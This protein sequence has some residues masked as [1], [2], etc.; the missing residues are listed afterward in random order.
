MPVVVIT[1]EEDQAMLLEFARLGISSYLVKPPKGKRVLEVAKQ[2][3]DA[4]EGWRA[5]QGAGT[6]EAGL[7]LEMVRDLYGTVTQ[8]I[9]QEVAQ[10]ACPLRAVFESPVYVRFIEF[11]QRHCP[12][13]L[14]D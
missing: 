12:R 5:R 13:A 11:L 3:L 1:T 7:S 14:E 8:S 10:P 4:S 9:E 2:A 6:D